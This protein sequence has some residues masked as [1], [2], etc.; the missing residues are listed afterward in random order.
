MIDLWQNFLRGWP[1]IAAT[2]GG[3]AALLKMH[4]TIG[5]LVAERQAHRL[6]LEAL[7]KVL[8]SRIVAAEHRLSAA[9][10]ADARIL[11]M[12]A[13]FRDVLLRFERT[14]GSMNDKL[15]RLVERRD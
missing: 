3:A 10:I 13:G 9:E 8:M 1:L 11:E 12:M 15:D 5:Q 6:E 7:E 4:L 2:V 14:Q